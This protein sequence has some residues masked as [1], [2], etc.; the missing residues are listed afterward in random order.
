MGVSGKDSVIKVGALLNLPGE[1]EKK[2]IENSAGRGPIVANYL[3]GCSSNF[4]YSDS[5]L[6]SK[7]PLN[8]FN[9]VSVEFK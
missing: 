6:R 8:A 2:L 1:C 5:I 7:V 3:T 9:F 4:D